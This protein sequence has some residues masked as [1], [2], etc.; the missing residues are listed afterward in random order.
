MSDKLEVTE[1]KALKRKKK[2]LETDVSQ[3]YIAEL[4]SDPNNRASTTIKVQVLISH[5]MERNN[6][7]HFIIQYYL[8]KIKIN[9]QNIHLTSF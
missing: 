3:N 2:A 5:S 8:V 4:Q 1:L 7:L 6:S 9:K